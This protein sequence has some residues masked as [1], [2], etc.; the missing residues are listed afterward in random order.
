[1]RAIAGIVAARR[2]SGAQEELLER[3]RGELGDVPEGSRHATV[4]V[5]L[6][7]AAWLRGDRSAAV[8]AVREAIESPTGSRFARP[9]GEMALWAARLGLEAPA[10]GAPEPVRLELAGD[11]RGAVR[12]WNE[13]EAPYEAALAALPGDERAARVALATL[14]RLG[15]TAAAAAFAR[16]RAAAGERAPRGPRRS[17]LAHPAGLTRREQEVLDR[18]ATGATNREI[19]GAMHLSERTVDHHVSAILRKFDV[20]NRLAATARARALGLLAQD[21]HSSLPR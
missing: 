7:E 8:A 21:G 19:A 3:A 4:R 12:A 11:W 10:P 18:L 6:V 13:L 5:A 17:T 14:R 9:A 2:G 1:A 20:P 16:E 15:A